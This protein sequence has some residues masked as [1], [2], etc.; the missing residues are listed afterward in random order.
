[1][2]Y[3]YF[4]PGPEGLQFKLPFRRH[5]GKYGGAEYNGKEEQQRNSGQ[6][7]G[8]FYLLVADQI[9]CCKQSNGKQQSDTDDFPGCPRSIMCYNN[10]I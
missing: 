10:L 2:V 1:M 4:P 5:S 3:D 8:A 9:T 7:L 6:C